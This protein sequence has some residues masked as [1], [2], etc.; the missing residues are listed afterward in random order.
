MARTRLQSA[1]SYL[2]DRLHDLDDL[3]NRLLRILTGQGSNMGT[4]VPENPVPELIVDR[5][6]VNSRLADIIR[7]EDLS[8][9][10]L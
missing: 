9:Y 6:F 10:I 1:D 3:S 7:D 2:R 8:R 4:E 5:E